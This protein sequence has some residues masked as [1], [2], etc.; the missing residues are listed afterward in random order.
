MEI[1]IRYIFKLTEISKTSRNN[2]KKEEL[3]GR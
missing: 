2:E 1:F 3:F